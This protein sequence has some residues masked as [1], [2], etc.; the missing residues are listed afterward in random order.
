MTT[1]L[2]LAGRTV[3]LA[4]SNFD[5]KILSLIDKAV[6]EVVVLKPTSDS[7]TYERPLPLDLLPYG[8]RTDKYLSLGTAFAISP[9]EYVTA[10]H[11]LALDRE[12]QYKEYFLRDVNG[13]VFS[14]DE[15]LKFSDRRDFAVFSVRGRNSGEY[16]LTNTRP[17]LHDKVYAVGNALGEGIV[18]RDGLF[19]STTPEDLNG[20]W[21]WL[22]FSAAAS[23]GNSGGPLLDGTGRVIGIVLRKSPNENLNI[24]LPIAEVVKAKDGV[25]QLDRKMYYFIDNMATTKI[26]ILRHEITLP[27][28]YRQLNQEL[29][30]AVDKF[31]AKLL[32]RLLDENKSQIFPNGRESLP[33]LHKSYDAVFPFLIFRG[34]DG[35]WDAQSAKET[36]DLELGNNGSVT[37]GYLGSSYFLY[38]QKPDNVQLETFYSDSKTFMD[39]ILKGL[40]ITRQIAVDKIRVTSFGK[41]NEES[42][43]TDGYRRKWLVRLWSMEYND[44]RVVTFSLPVPGGC[45]TM[46]RHDQTG[47]ISGHI[48]DLK[49]LADFV[50]VSYYGTLKQWREFLAMK[51]LLPEVLSGI[52]IEFESGGTFRYGS[53]R[54]GFRAGKEI[55]RLTENSDLKLNFGYFPEGGRIQWDVKDVVLGEDKNSA[56]SFLVS[57]M[58]R[59]PDELSDRYKSEWEKM[60]NRKMPY[61]KT[62]YLNEK[63]SV[64]STVY[65]EDMTG[66]LMG[67]AR[68][69]Y[70]VSYTKEGNIGQEAMKA[71]L[72]GFLKNIEVYELVNK[73]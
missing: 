62:S 23:P 41:A 65:P 54:L 25:A 71:A 6:F 66:N 72:D 70:R 57:R 47:R 17:E 56:T 43:F 32:E 11:V 61:N 5:R 24:A 28:P 15:I 45:I 27:K 36:R 73:Q 2:L 30:D 39:T 22:R 46:M 63:T 67:K 51:A 53:R 31:A 60:I 69:L 8:E 19:T 1:A 49:A 13:A 21:K 52:A 33:L 35:I 34:A 18:I 48:M 58:T 26:D 4:E 3:V 38:V 20:E 42:V 64:I 16:L 50:Y 9:T 40:G 7:L 44:Q 59:P 55:L 37:V 12:S 68:L 10:A 29:T 14:I